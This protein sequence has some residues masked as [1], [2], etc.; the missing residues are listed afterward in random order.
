MWGF[1][2]LQQRAIL[3]LL[4]SFAVGSA[5][6]FYR[7]QR[8]LPAVPPEVVAQFEQYAAELRADT[9]RGDS[10]SSPSGV[11]AA[12]RQPHT[13]VRPNVNTA[14]ASELVL[15]PGIG[16]TMAKRIIA[17]REQHGRFRRWD[18]LT[19]VQGIGKRKLA[20][21]QKEATLE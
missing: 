18:D 13:R 6:R 9:S 3:F 20:T 14:T 4:A 21:L 15:L 7:Q 10:A 17:Y 12:D 19:R 16:V 1:T 2:P 5:I 11:R 8:P